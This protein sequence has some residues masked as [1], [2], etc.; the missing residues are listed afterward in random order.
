MK[1]RA[2]PPAR[3]ELLAWTAGLGASTADALAC[4][5][6][7]TVASARASLGAAAHDRQ[8]ARHKPLAEAQTLYTV[9][10]VGLRAGAI[11]GLEPCRVSP[12]GARHMIVSAWVAAAL[13]R[14]YPDATV[15]GEPALRLRERASGMPFASS[16]LEWEGPR[17]KLLHRP[18]LA[19]VPSGEGQRP[20]AIEVELTVKAPRRLAEICRAWA[21]SRHVEGVIYLAPPPVRRA[22]ER[23]IAAS[24]AEASVV[25]VSLDSVA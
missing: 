23:A 13:E 15:I 17:G 1:H 24:Q 12:A 5:S 3:A 8:L 6:G 22:V 9:T 25:V 21:R 14:R 11:E 10:R 20:I 19:L 4:R 2:I 7:A 16:V 18:D